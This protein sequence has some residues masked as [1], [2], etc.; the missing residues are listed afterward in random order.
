MRIFIA[1]TCYDLLDLR[2]E[3]EEFFRQAGVNPVLSD[4]LTSDF[5]VEPDGN[6]IQTC[7]ANVR[8][9]DAFVI[10]LSNRYGPSLAKAGFEDISATH[11]EYREAVKSKKPIHMYVRD[12]LEADFTTWKTNRDR[13]NLNLPWCKEKRDWK[14]FELLQEHRKLVEG[15][16]RSNWLSL[17]RTSTEL[18]Q[19]LARHFK[20]TF[21]R[22][23]ISRLFENGRIPFLQVSGI[24]TQQ[25]R[26]ECKLDLTIRNVSGAI[27]VSPHLQL[28][29]RG[30][31]ERWEFSS[32][33][34]GEKKE[35]VVRLRLVNSGEITMETLLGYSI[36][37]GEQFSDHGTLIIRPDVANS[38]GGTIV[39]K[40]CRREYAGSMPEMK[41]LHLAQKP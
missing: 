40:V 41:T 35:K 2:A 9:C 11:L 1:S 16:T 23:L 17:F 34:G 20:E 13:A 24:I 33:A 29:R 28:Q 32:L 39:Y 15:S 4:S 5:Q 19:G 8:N 31:Q 10:V 38:G 3:L 27:A 26:K 12:R 18:K 37:E 14:L 36:I 21:D 22:V 30:Y 6:S 25:V 7:L